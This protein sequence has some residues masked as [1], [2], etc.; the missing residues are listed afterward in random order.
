M[1]VRGEGGK[2]GEREEVGERLTQ[3]YKGPGV[4][5]VEAPRRTDHAR[6]SAH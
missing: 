5:A 2:L 6:A 1:G 4:R 3:L